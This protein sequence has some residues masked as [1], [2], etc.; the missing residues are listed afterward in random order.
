MNQSDRS[1][2]RRE[3]GRETRSD[4]LL[5]WAPVVV[6]GALVAYGLT[7]RSKGGLMMAAAGGALAY[8]TY[9]SSRQVG[10]D[11]A[12]S[13]LLVNAT[14]D[15]VFAFWRNFENLP[16]FMHH[17]KSVKDLGGNR[18]QWIAYGPAGA[19]VE[20]TADIVAETPGKLI[21]WRSAEGSDVQMDGS[22]EFRKAPAGRGTFVDA[23]VQYRPPAGALGTRVAKLFGKDP[24]F[25]IEQ[26]LRRFKALIETGEIPTVEGQSHGPRSAVAAAARALDP[27]MPMRKQMEKEPTPAGRR[28]S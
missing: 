18:S 24:S 15:Q 4:T 3:S 12:R 11:F 2:P 10:A 19:T 22:I 27:D 7:R 5:R 16:R 6:G 17:L 1:A 28:V 8:Q 25:L 26:D 20:W 9:P 21:A 14:P 13:T 23:T